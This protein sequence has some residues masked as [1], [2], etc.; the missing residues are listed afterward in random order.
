MVGGPHTKLANLTN[1]QD[2]TLSNILLDNLAI[3][4]FFGSQNFVFLGLSYYYENS[5]RL[6]PPTKTVN[7]SNPNLLI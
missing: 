5:F 1:V 3:Q 4:K 2:A 6:L 7:F